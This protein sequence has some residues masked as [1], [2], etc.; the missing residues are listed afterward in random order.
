MEG[1]LGSSGVALGLL[2]SLNLLTNDLAAET[3]KI[4][5]ELFSYTF[6]NLFHP[7]WSQ[8]YACLSFSHLSWRL[9]GRVHIRDTR[10][11]LKK[12]ETEFNIYR[13]IW[14][15][16]FTASRHCSESTRTSHSPDL[17]CEAGKPTQGFYRFTK[18][19]L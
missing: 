15:F 19:D 17:T 13:R 7:L 4:D 9:P 14:S 2:L 16:V 11:I 6:L 8:L 10:T 1:L 3:L 5:T 12:K 18:K